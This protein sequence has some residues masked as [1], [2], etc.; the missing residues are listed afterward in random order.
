M[1]IIMNAIELCGVNKSYDNFTLNN[2]SFSVPKGCGVGL[3]G[4]NGAGK[5]TILKA[6]LNLIHIDSGAIMLF[7]KDHTKQEILTREKIGTVFEEC[8]FPPYLN[9]PEV[10]NVMQHIYRTWDKA[11]FL[12]YLKQFHLPE[13][14]RVK[15][16]S[17]GMK[18]KL[19]IAAALADHPSLLILDEATSGLDP[20]VREEILD[21]LRDFIQS[22]ENSILLSSHITTDLDKIADYITFIHE[23]NIMF[24]E[25]K[26]DLTDRLGIL[27]CSG[28]DFSQLMPGECIRFRR[29]AFGMEALVR[30]RAAA[31]R[32]FPSAVID[33]VTIEDI[34]LFYIRG[35]Q[36]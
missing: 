33:P 18:M 34:M 11:A 1:D 21:I 17:R 9:A 7:G 15:E 36:L 20:I 25:T 10:S 26:D 3:I 31:R 16:Y 14:K 32:K 5:S 6:I 30:D 23:G 22:E 28:E 24:H 29:Q 19:S 4:E 12:S 2:V 35:E 27:R 8:E 13:K